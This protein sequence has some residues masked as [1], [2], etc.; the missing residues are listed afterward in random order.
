M[1]RETLKLPL[2]LVGAPLK[3]QAPDRVTPWIAPGLPHAQ[4]GLR[5]AFRQVSPRPLPAVFTIEPLA[6]P[7]QPCSFRYMVAATPQARLV[8]SRKTTS[9]AEC[10]HSVSKHLWMRGMQTSLATIPK[11][12]A[13]AYEHGLTNLSTSQKHLR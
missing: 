1:Y 11:P 3:G 8:W 7:P 12:R 6:E 10:K 9:S 5:Y 2:V 4:V 13:R